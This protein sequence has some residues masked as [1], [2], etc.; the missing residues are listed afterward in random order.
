MKELG[1][2]E[3][4][5]RKYATIRAKL[6]YEFGVMG[7]SDDRSVIYNSVKIFIT[8]MCEVRVNKTNISE[9]G[10]QAKQSRLGT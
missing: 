5:R 9:G 2:E 8:D 3:I 1:T 4:E 10:E 6:F 7:D